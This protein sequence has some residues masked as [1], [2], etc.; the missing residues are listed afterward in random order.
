MIN[1]H[2]E[3][4]FGKISRGWSFAG[5]SNPYQVVECHNGTVPNIVSFCSIG[6]CS[7]ELYSKKSKK[8][9]KHEIMLSFDQSHVPI[10]AVAIIKQMADQAIKYREPYLDNQIITR[11]GVLFNEACFTGLWVKPPVFFGEEAFVYYGDDTQGY[12]CIMAWLVPLFQSE[13][14]FIK[15]NG[16]DRF[17]DILVG[18][19]A[20]LFLTTRQSVVFHNGEI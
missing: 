17:E 2:I 14:D 9:I 8:K 18:S 1:N 12:P 3:K 5:D 4:H 7:V 20:D 19:A 16:A 6:L 13:I 11:P 15:Q 10:N